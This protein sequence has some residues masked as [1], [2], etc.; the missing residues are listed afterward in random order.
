MKVQATDRHGK[1]HAGQ[2][3]KSVVVCEENGAPLVVIKETVVGDL[4]NYKILTSE[5][6]EFMVLARSLGFDVS[7][8]KI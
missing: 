7:V 4:R 2:Q 1:T 3:I 6:Q 8:R 5:D